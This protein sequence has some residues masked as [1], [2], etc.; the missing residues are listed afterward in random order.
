MNVAGT[1]TCSLGQQGIQHADDGRVIA[2][3]QQILNRGQVLHHARQVGVALHLANHSRSVG[4]AI[5][6]GRR[7]AL[8][9]RIYGLMCHM[10]Y[11]VFTC[12]F[13][14]ATQETAAVQP[15]SQL[16]PIFLQQH[17]LGT[18]K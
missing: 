14:D 15:Q 6:I 2:G 11:S 10:L 8:E 1:V 16:V 12:D 13:A 4:F 9:Q 17:L 7:D 3:F 18:G 5:G